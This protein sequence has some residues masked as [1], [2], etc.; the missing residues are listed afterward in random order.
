MLFLKRAILAELTI[1]AALFT[2]TASTAEIVSTTADASLPALFGSASLI[3]TGQVASVDSGAEVI[4]DWKGQP[5]RLRQF[6][7][8]IIPDRIYKGEPGTPVRVVYVR[9]T[10][11]VCAVSKCVSMN[12]GEYGLF[13][14][15]RQGE[16]YQ[17]LD[18]LY[19]GF[20]VSRLKSPGVLKGIQEVEADLIAGFRDEDERRVL[21]NVELFGGLEHATSILPL[22]DLLQLYPAGTIEGAAYVA[23][24]R[25]HRYTKLREAAI[26]SER[27]AHDPTELAIQDR[28]C[29]LIEVIDDPAA[30]QVLI[31]LAQAR[32]DRLRGAVIH[33][34]RNITSAAAVPVFVGALDDTVNLIR[35]DAVMGLAAVERNPQL[36]PSV[37]AFLSNESEYIGAWKSWWLTSGKKSYE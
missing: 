26:F 11:R 33:A 19:Q 16:N 18:G 8:T 32:S 9:P 5:E 2:S 20:G 37:S 34:L 6:T 10:G 24:L 12:P 21:T 31:S 13:F 4:A 17:V 22:L 25:L 30:S 36:A 29:G 23:L 7:S 27:S 14:L 1:L 28:I 35:Y 15:R 3:L